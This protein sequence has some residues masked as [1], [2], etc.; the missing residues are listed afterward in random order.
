[1]PDTRRGARLRLPPGQAAEVARWSAAGASGAYGG[2]RPAGEPAEAAVPEWPAGLVPE[3]AAAAAR[4]GRDLGAAGVLRVAG[5]AVPAGLPPTPG[6]P[7]VEVRRPVGTER[8][9]LALAGL[10][11]EVISFADWHGGDRVQN[12]Y[13][14]PDQATGQSASNAVHLEMHTETAFRPNTPDGVIL[15]CLR[16]DQEARTL[17]C[18]LLDLWPRFDEATRRA[19][20]EPAFAF[21]L[22]GGTTTEPKPVVTRWRD[23]P[24]F[25]YADAL[26]ATGPGHDAALRTLREAIA[27]EA[28]T[29]TLRAGDLLFIDNVHV[30]HGRTGYRPRYD[31]TDRWLQRCL[32]RA[33]P[34]GAR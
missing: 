25:N 27:A 18:D 5:V 32:I 6:R 2:D 15:L 10:A 21:R 24:R 29:V 26:C 31:G 7:Y 9:L 30:V 34:V 13:P 3:V 23:R 8:L 16:P 28:A 22:P 33:A 20:A 19:L 14:L 1:M 11:G 17:V 12:L 4:F